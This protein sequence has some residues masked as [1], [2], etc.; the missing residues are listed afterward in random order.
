[1]YVRRFAT[2]HGGEWS[3][4]SSKRCLAVPRARA[5]LDA[6]AK[7]SVSCSRRETPLMEA[8]HGGDMDG[9]LKRECTRLLL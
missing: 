8:K 6:G 7:A 5:L 2:A 1:M 9:R 3:P 4:S